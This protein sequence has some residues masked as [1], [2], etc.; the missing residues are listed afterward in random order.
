MARAKEMTERLNMKTSPLHMSQESAARGQALKQ[1][2]KEIGTEAW[3]PERG[4]SSW[5]ERERGWSDA[6]DVQGVGPKI[7]L[8]HRRHKEGETLLPWGNGGGGTKKKSPATQPFSPAP[9]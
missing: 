8:I 9:A 3:N 5:E 7:G 4:G 2:S 6:L 1:A